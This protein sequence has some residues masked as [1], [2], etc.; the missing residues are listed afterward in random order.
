MPKKTLKKFRIWDSTGLSK[1]VPADSVE[2]ERK[3]NGL[4]VNFTTGK[5]VEILKGIVCL[6]EISPAIVV[7]QTKNSFAPDDE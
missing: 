3:S 5:N 6:I 4:T 2:W 7:K 1:I